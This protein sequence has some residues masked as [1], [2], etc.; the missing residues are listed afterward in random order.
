MSNTRTDDCASGLHEYCTPCECECHKKWQ[1]QI[2]DLI[3]LMPD[4]QTQEI[5]DFIFSMRAVR[6]VRPAAADTPQDRTALVAM[7]GTLAVM[8]AACT[9]YHPTGELAPS[10]FV[11]RLKAV[12]DA[13]EATPSSETCKFCEH[14]LA[15]HD[16][17]G[18]KARR[19]DCMPESVRV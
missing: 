10:Y 9:I 11:T 5:V 12:A 19:C 8:L 7:L 14:P 18:C 15:D 6:G 4:S 16:A 13:L 1:Q 2:L 3:K 17:Y